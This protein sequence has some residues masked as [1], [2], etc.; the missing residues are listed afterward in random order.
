M[1]P[2]Y[3]CSVYIEHTPGVC[4]LLASALQK[5]MAAAGRS[6][7]FAKAAVGS[8]RSYECPPVGHSVLG[9]T[10]GRPVVL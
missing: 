10:V 6:K 9:L 5:G 3:R 2:V 8:P 7:Y 1:L 4:L